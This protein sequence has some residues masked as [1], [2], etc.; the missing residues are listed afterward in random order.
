MEGAAFGMNTAEMLSCDGSGITFV[1][2]IHLTP[3]MGQ[4]HFG[5]VVGKVLSAR[6]VPTKIASPTERPPVCLSFACHP[7]GR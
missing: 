3:V 2:L 1:A 5:G 6:T 4:R 7:K